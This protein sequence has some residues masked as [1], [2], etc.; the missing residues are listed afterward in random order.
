LILI[1]FDDELILP[2]R[3][4]FVTLMSARNLVVLLLLLLASF[5]FTIQQPPFDT[6]T[7][8]KASSTNK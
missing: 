7:D 5:H 1:L 3:L 8:N 6:S 4:L 2:S